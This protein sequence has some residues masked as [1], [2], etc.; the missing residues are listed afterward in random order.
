MLLRRQLVN[1]ELQTLQVRWRL[2][3]FDQLASLSRPK[4]SAVQGIFYVNSDDSR[5]VY[6][7]ALQISP[8]N[9]SALATSPP[10]HQRFPNVASL[11]VWT[12]PDG[13]G[14]PGP[15]SCLIPQLDSFF[16]RDASRMAR[17]RALDVS[18]IAKS[19]ALPAVIDS[20]YLCT[21]L[22]TLQL[23]EYMANEI[24]PLAAVPCLEGLATVRFEPRRPS[25]PRQH[26][27]R[28]RR[29]ILRFYAVAARLAGNI[30]FEVTIYVGAGNSGLSDVGA[31]QWRR[32]LVR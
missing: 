28:R 25:W 2:A 20:V 32:R 16:Q 30:E 4:F 31:R 18:G 11:T 6:H 1:N 24:G 3:V 8:R 12:I 22:V 9:D 14:I 21:Q 23:P 5:Y 29:R 26:T 19:V 13:M 27:T 15:P 10:L 7:F 17:L